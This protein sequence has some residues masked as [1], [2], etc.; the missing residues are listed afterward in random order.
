MVTA[1]EEIPLPLDDA[2]AVRVIGAPRPVLSAYNWRSNAYLIA[3][4]A[5]LGYLDADWHVL[6]ATY[7]KG[8]WWDQWRPAQ[9]TTND[10]DAGD[11]PDVVADFRALPFA[12][13]TFDAVAYDPPYITSGGDKSTICAFKARYGLDTVPRYG[14]E[15]RE[16]INA[17]LSEAAR[18]VK[19]RGFVLMKCKNYV[20]AAIFEAGVFMAWDHGT[21][22]DGLELVDAMVHL[23]GTGPQQRGRP[24]RHSRSNYSTLLVFRKGRK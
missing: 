23:S 19:P 16:L 7:G 15:L 4:C 21:K 12:D 3:D 20:E 1:W 17:G 13:D 22:G 10:I 8:R 5:R 18:V 24:Q 6:D 2:P 14:R 9:L 11:E